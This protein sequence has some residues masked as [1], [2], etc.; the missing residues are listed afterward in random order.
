MAIEQ[1]IA[2]AFRANSDS[3]ELCFAD[4]IFRPHLHACSI[5]DFVIDKK[6]VVWS[7]YILCG[8]RGMMEEVKD[9]VGVD[10]L[11]V[12]SIPPASGLSSTSKPSNMYEYK[13]IPLAV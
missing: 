9:P 12:S 5:A 2:I 6:S 11:V 4:L 13:Q 1:D 10:V 7:S 3:K 8:I